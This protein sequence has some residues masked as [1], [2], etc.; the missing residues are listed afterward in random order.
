MAIRSF[1]PLVILAPLI[2]IPSAAYADAFRA[3]IVQNL[4]QGTSLLR[5]K[6]QLEKENR[7]LLVER[8]DLLKTGTALTQAE[9]DLNRQAN[10]HN[11]EAAAQ[12]DA[13]Q[14]NLN[15]CSGANAPAGRDEVSSCNKDIDALNGKTASINT[16]ADELQAKQTDLQMR[17]AR[18]QHA[19]ADWN[20]RDAALVANLN[21]LGTYLTNWLNF[22]YGFLAGGDFQAA[23]LSP[24]AVK[25][26]GTGVD[27]I[28]VSARQPMDESA[29]Y[30]LGCLKAVNRQ[31]A[32]PRQ[33]G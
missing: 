11:Q 16:S 20:K 4:A 33:G 19:V 21:R 29:A 14:N 6:A 23:I 27:R 28:K 25:A 10:A 3:Q 9:A 18:Y 8:Q 7:Q 5:Q 30:V 2:S 24:G 12:K 22:N 15:T 31:Y 13:I 32:T 1:L 26:C 17:Y